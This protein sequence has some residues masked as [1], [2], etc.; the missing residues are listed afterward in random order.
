MFRPTQQK[1][2][3]MDRECLM[4]YLA[5]ETSN[6][7]DVNFATSFRRCK[8]L[9]NEEGSATRSQRSVNTVLAAHCKEEEGG[10]SLVATPKTWPRGRGWRE[11]GSHA[12]LALSNV[13]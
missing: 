1:K 4:G 13:S 11:S 9:E 2:Q 12:R 3:D 10:A 6:I 5:Y 8:S 7:L